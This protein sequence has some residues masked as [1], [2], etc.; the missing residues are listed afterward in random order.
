MKLNT[1]TGLRDVPK[2][3]DNFA[4]GGRARKQQRELDNSLNGLRETRKLEGIDARTNGKQI[5]QRGM[6]LIRQINDE[7]TPPRVYLETANVAKQAT[8]Q[9]KI[10]DWGQDLDT[11]SQAV[12]DLRKAGEVVEQN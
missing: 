8:R 3:G 9:D 11:P 1:I 6:T 5:W 12:I 10:T 4:I 7:I 2:T